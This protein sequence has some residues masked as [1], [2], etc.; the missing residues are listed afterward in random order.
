MRL[1]AIG[2]DLCLNH[3][4]H[5]AIDAC[6]VNG[7]EWWKLSFCLEFLSYN[8]PKIQSKYQSCHTELQQVKKN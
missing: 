7:E 2:A 5:I 1:V 8:A 6:R 4:R 3:L